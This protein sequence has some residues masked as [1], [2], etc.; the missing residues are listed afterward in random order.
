M[1]YQKEDVK[2]LNNLK[3]R[4]VCKECLRGSRNVKKM[5]KDMW[6]CLRCATIGCGRRA[7]AHALDHY[8]KTHHKLSVNAQTM[9]L[10]CYKCDYDLIEEGLQLSLENDNSTFEEYKEH[11]EEMHDYICDIVSKRCHKN[12]ESNGDKTTKRSLGDDSS[13]ARYYR[14]SSY[15]GVKINQID[16][17][18]IERR[19]IPN[20][21]NQEISFDEQDFQTD[22]YL[23]PIIMKLR[24]DHEPSSK[25]DE[26]LF[27]GKGLR[28][29]GNTCFFNSTMQC[30][31]ATRDLFFLLHEN[32]L[33]QSGRGFAFND[34]FS[35][36]ILEMRES[37]S[38]TIS[39]SDLFRA[40]V[41]KNARFRGYQQQ[42]AHDLL[43]MLIEN[44]DKEALKKK[45][46]PI[47][48][49]VF[50][51]K[52]LT[53]VLCLTCNQ[54]SRTISQ[55]NNLM[56]EIAFST[57]K[58]SKLKLKYLQKNKVQSVRGGG[59][60][61]LSSEAKEYLKSDNSSKKSD[62]FFKRL[63]W[64]CYKQ[65]RERKS[66]S[67]ADHTE[68]SLSKKSQT[69]DDEEEKIPPKKAS[70]NDS[71]I[72]DYQRRS[73]KTNTFYKKTKDADDLEGQK[74]NERISVEDIKETAN[75]MVK[76]AEAQ[77]KDPLSFRFRKVVDL[78]KPDKNT[79]SESK[80]NDSE[81]SEDGET[82]RR[83]S[84]IESEVS[85]GESSSRNESRNSSLNPRADNYIQH[86]SDQSEELNEGKF[87]EESTIHFEPTFWPTKRSRYFTLE[88]CLDYYVE[89][90]LLNDKKNLYQCE[91]CTLLKY[92]KKSKKKFESPAIKRSVILELPLNLIINLKRF[93]HSRYSFQKSRKTVVYPLYLK[94][95]KYTMT[96]CDQEDLDCYQKY[97]NSTFQDKWKYK[98]IYELYGIVSHSG[99]MSGGH[100]ISYVCY[101]YGKNRTWF[102]CSDSS[103]RKVKEE[104][105]LDT[106]AY[107]LFYRKL[108]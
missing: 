28:N 76:E 58:N 60:Y 13:P 71:E 72:D 65:E 40:I 82:P 29:L 4:I 74:S 33:K 19:S 51:G 45:K 48:E 52:M 56:L 105:A 57:P 46:K 69:P 41:R 94:M 39:P 77:E 97:S 88:E 95:D 21:Q 79:E 73:T 38:E 26:I 2:E 80:S 42:D 104:S 17:E 102:Y 43:M 100:Y 103:V 11:V 98:H 1:R 9:S 61:K 66:L 106:E 20:R 3:N 86:S 50:G 101:K 24:K 22:S 89:V 12:V 27:S 75:D 91:N 31:T 7:K 68:K 87:G 92:G 23:S 53:C 54:V 35:D 62:C 64:C 10:W 34:I 55:Y 99:S 59:D 36:F 78:G 90:E 16:D 107:I 30:L 14:T 93:T 49:H 6:I 81:E 85:G 67:K 5:S 84:D 44:L 70:F 18:Q 15:H 83:S 96:E 108:S 8:K 63:F 32:P 37:S 25:V 47:M